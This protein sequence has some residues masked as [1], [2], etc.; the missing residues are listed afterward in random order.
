[1]RK[2]FI[3]MVAAG[4]LVTFGMGPVKADPPNNGHDCAGAF[5]SNNAGPGFGQGVSDAAHN[6]QV[7]NFGVADCGQPPRQNP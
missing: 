1:M 2:L 5:V 7:D 3:G 4:A 6:Q